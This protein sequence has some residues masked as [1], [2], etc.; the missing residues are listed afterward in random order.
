MKKRK[1]VSKAK[2]SNMPSTRSLFDLGK[3]VFCNGVDRKTDK[4]TWKLYD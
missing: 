4:Q 3:L 2:I 1:V